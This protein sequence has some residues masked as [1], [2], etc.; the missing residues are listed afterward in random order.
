[1]ILRINI[2]K[3]LWIS[4]FS[5]QYSPLLGIQN[6]DVKNRNKAKQNSIHFYQL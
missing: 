6:N 4:G 3:F 2:E 1:M 5:G